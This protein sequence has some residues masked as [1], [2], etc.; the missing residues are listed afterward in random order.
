MFSGFDDPIVLE[1]EDTEIEETFFVDRE[2]E[3]LSF[4]LISLNVKDFVA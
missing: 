3:V 2:L 1:L 4:S